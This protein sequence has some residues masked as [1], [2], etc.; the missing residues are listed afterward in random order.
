MA[1][2]LR[3][4]SRDA[5][6]PTFAPDGLYFVGPY[7]DA[8][9]AHPRTHAGHGLAA[10]SVACAMRTRIKICGLTREADVDAAVQAGAD[11]IGFVLYDTQRA[12]C[13]APSVPAALARRLPP[14]V[15]PVLLLVNASPELLQAALQAVPQALLQFHGDETPAQCEAPQPRLPARRAHGTG[16]RFVR[17]CARASPAHRPCC[18]TPMSKVMAGVERFSIGHSFLQAC[19]FRSFCLVG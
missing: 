13:V 2:V 6:A 19:P 3:A 7:Y 10:L 15:T 8:R 16:L 1:E 4:R 9:H 5:A 18:S 17:L 12:P 14:F 11:A